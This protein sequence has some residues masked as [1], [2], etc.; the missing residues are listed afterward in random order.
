LRQFRI[1]ASDAVRVRGV[2]ATSK[3]DDGTFAITVNGAF[4]RSFMSA[5][6]SRL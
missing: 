5:A 2:I 1:L 3:M 6:A 4:M